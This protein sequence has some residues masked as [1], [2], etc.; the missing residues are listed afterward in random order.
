MRLDAIRNL[1]PPPLILLPIGLLTF[2]ILKEDVQINSDASLS[3]AETTATATAKGTMSS[4]GFP[5]ALLEDAVITALSERPLFSPTRTRYEP[6]K[7]VKTPQ[8]APEE[9]VIAPT[10][11]P[12]IPP[13]EV[14]FL[15][16]I[17]ENGTYS[18]LLKAQNEEKWYR[19]GDRIGDWTI[20]NVYGDHINLGHGEQ[21]ISVHLER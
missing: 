9:I 4:S 7:K 11:P 1:I 21:T 2:L 16:V 3:P 20:L 15:G 12:D 8:Q 6:V 5:N 10:K 14:E 13:P 17:S 19:S 18:A